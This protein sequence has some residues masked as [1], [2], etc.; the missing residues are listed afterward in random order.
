VVQCSQCGAQLP[1]NTRFCT[2]CGAAVTP[3]AAPQAPQ[4]EAVQTSKPPK[5]SMAILWGVIGVLAMIL[6]AVGSALPWATASAMMITVSKGGLSG[7]GVI[8]II[9]AVLGLVFFA[10]GMTGKARWAFVIGFILSLLVLAVSIY[11]AVD[12]TRAVGNV[13]ESVNVD[14]GI[15]LIV[16]II[17]GAIGAVCAFAGILAPKKSS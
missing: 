12:I 16:C 9:L 17:G 10:I 8:T 13:A 5:S 6:V 3:P 11:D 2:N 4:A 15:G 7:D 1:D 14:V